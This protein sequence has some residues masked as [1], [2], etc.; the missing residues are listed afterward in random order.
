MAIAGYSLGHSGKH[1]RDYKGDHA[2]LLV[3]YMFQLSTE[4]QR[5]LLSRTPTTAAALH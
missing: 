2:D 4:E 5:M 3:R 1:M